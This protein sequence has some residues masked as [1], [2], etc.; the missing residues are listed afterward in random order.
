MAGGLLLRDRMFLVDAHAFFGNDRRRLLRGLARLARAYGT[1]SIVVFDGAPTRDLP[2]GTY[3][4]S[5]NVLYRGQHASTR[6]RI[7]SLVV[8]NARGSPFTVVTSDRTLAQRVHAHG[9]R[10]VPFALLQRTLALAR[11][12]IPYGVVVRGS[13]STTR[14][15]PACLAS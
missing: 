14:S 6:A 5:V 3:R 12:A 13:A 4:R 7:A 9:A 10:V 11:L 1:P 2:S 8:R 15:R